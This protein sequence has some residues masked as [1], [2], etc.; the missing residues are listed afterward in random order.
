MDKV[1]KINIEELKENLKQRLASI[2]IDE[3]QITDTSYMND[4]Q[5]GIIDTR[6]PVEPRKTYSN[7]YEGELLQRFDETKDYEERLDLAN[8]IKKER[9]RKLIKKA[10]EEQRLEKE[11]NIKSDFLS[12]LEVKQTEARADIE[13]LD[14]EIEKVEAKQAEILQQ[15]ADYKS[16][17]KLGATHIKQNVYTVVEEEA[18]KSQ[19]TANKKIK[20]LAKLRKQREIAQENFDSLEAYI[21][22]LSSPIVEES[23]IEEPIAEEP[24]VEEPAIEDPIVEE[25]AI[26][27]PIVE[28][29]AIEEPIVEKPVIE[30]TIAE[31]PVVEEPISKKDKIAEQEEQ[32][33]PIRIEPD[34]FEQTFEKLENNENE[35]EFKLNPEVFEANAIGE[36][37]EQI[38]IGL[39]D[40]DFEQIKNIFKIPENEEPTKKDT[41]QIDPKVFEEIQKVFAQEPAKT[42]TKTTSKVTNVN[43]SQAPLKKSNSG[44]KQTPSAKKPEQRQASSKQSQYYISGVKFRLFVGI[45]E[46]SVV[47]KSNDPSVEPIEYTEWDAY[48]TESVPEKISKSVTDAKKF[49]DQ[50]VANILEKVDKKYGTNGLQQYIDLLSKKYMYNKPKNDLNIDYDFS[51]LGKISKENKGIIKN[52]KKLAKAN[53]KLGLATYEKTP[54]FLQ[55][56]WN[57]IK[58]A[59]LNPASDTK[60]RNEF[61]DATLYNRSEDNLRIIEALESGIGEPGFS[62]EE[63]AKAYDLTDKQLETYM[64]ELKGIDRSKLWRLKNKSQS[65]VEE[66]NKS[67]AQEKESPEATQQVS[68]DLE[69]TEVVREALEQKEEER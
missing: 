18:K 26:D 56:I 51:Y 69:Q 37:K 14:V 31:E 30:E 34:D 10:E 50:N 58:T 21:Q 65:K 23:T 63:F 38:G 39:D 46:Y 67:E 6:N 27:E 1:E 15:I 3:V 48:E 40:D 28:E 7:D 32:K 45:P 64:N 36:Q 44:V 54:N 13:I 49:Y 57:K 19:K 11:Q 25:P 2:V 66:T 12:E 61:I 35:Q 5:V 47:I 42:E 62:L 53:S 4:V 8:K 59:R 29:P 60:E 17:L 68:E 41:T 52:I 33:E 43:T 16:F 22:E 55:K 24:I 9:E 20:Q